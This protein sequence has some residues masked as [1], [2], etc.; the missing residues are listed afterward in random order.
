[1]PKIIE[2]SNAQ[3]LVTIPKQLAIA[4]GFEKGDKVEWR[5]NKSGKLELEK[6]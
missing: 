6:V 2:M 4:L 5:I 3:K 1:M